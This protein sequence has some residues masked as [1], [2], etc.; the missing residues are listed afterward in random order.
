MPRK[1]LPLAVDIA[2]TVS[3]AAE[4]G[5]ALDVEATAD[6]LL[7]KHPEAS[8]ARSDVAET[9]REESEAAGVEEQDKS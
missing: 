6:E 3:Q 5:S 1:K 2:D 8:V 4:D 7:E 9:L